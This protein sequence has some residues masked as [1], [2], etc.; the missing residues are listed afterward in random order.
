M[1]RSRGISTVLGALLFTIV[2]FLL[3]ALALRVFTESTATLTEVASVAAQNAV[4]ER[5]KIA[6]SYTR[7][8]AYTASQA[9]ATV[10]P[11]LGEKEGDESLLDQLDG[12]SLKLVSAATQAGQ[13]QQPQSIELVRN[14]DFSE[15]GNYWELENPW[16]VDT[17]LQC[18]RVDTTAQSINASLWQTV[19]IPLGLQ[20]LTLSFSYYLYAHPPGQVNSLSL[21]VEILQDGQTVWSASITW[22]RN[23]NPTEGVFSQSIPI[24]QLSLGN[25]AVINFTLRLSAGKDLQSLD[26]RLDNVSLV[27]AVAGAPPSPVGAAYLAAVRIDLSGVSG[28]CT[29]TMA[30]STTGFVEVYV[31]AA[32]GVWA[33][34]S[35][36]YVE[37]GSRWFNATFAGSAALIYAYSAQP[38]E[39]LLDYLQ[40]EVS[41]PSRTVD[42]TVENVGTAPVTVYAVW[43]NGT[44][45]PVG[46]LLP[47]GAALSVPFTLDSEPGGFASFEVRVVTSTR[48]HVARFA[49]RS[50]AP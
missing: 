5:L 32:D 33:M 40:V 14:G 37:G 7:V 30:L 50:A 42:V 39:A 2:A 29:L 4:E 15:D 36:Y 1:L 26:V 22:D 25:N 34:V 8:V 27:A 47:P 21:T 10:T 46:Q 6:A 17:T 3:I 48:T 45:S 41:Q 16:R 13:Q 18:A 20:S 49:V 43:L 24:E 11:L 12:N 31:P 19:N 9:G 23:R 38:F 44:R 35:K 28:N